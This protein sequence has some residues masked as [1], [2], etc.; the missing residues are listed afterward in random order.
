VATHPEVD[1]RPA[2][3]VVVMTMLQCAIAELE[4][5]GSCRRAI[6]AAGFPKCRVC[7]LYDREWAYGSEATYRR[8]LLGLGPGVRTRGWRSPTRARVV[9]R[10]ATAPIR[11]ANDQIA[12]NRPSKAEAEAE[13]AP[14]CIVG[15]TW[16]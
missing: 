4:R 11:S 1:G 14:A 7:R 6:P 10:R 9:A 5:S 3:A 15:R 8:P 16:E 2:Q 13:A 12:A